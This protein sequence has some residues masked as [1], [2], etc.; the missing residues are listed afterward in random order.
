MN[1]NVSSL[2]FELD[3]AKADTERYRRVFCQVA[4]CADV[5]V[6]A[7]A[8]GAISH[9]EAL[10]AMRRHACTLVSAVEAL[11]ARARS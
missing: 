6:Q 9:N 4:R 11:A 10:Q 8:E 2:P 5:V 7:V 3:R 1:A